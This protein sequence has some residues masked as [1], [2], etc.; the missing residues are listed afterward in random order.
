MEH[1]LSPALSWL[2]HPGR[3]LFP[4]AIAL[5]MAVGDLR[6]RRIPNYLTLGTALA[7][8]AVRLLTDGLPGL[9]DGFLGLL[10]GFCLLFGFYLA[11]G[12]GAGDVKA[13][14]ALGTWLGL[15][16]TLFLF[17]Y[18]ALAGGVL[19]LVYLCWRGLL[20]A[21]L[22]R[23]GSWLLS[24]VLLRPHGGG[25][26]AAPGT[27]PE[28]ATGE[29]VPYGVALALGMVFLCWQVLSR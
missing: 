26:G 29:G 9:A 28:A 6:T 14:A 16:L 2:A 3:F 21:K 23:L 7:G 8:L 1:F 11:G 19:T 15:R 17:L 20:L 5:W 25:A 27:G 13:L 4:T 10:V 22:K 24:W 18:M 12:M